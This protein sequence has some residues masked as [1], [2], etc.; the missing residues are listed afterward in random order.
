[1]YVCGKEIW[2]VETV[3]G[4]WFLWIDFTVVYKTPGTIDSEATESTFEYRF[5]IV[6]VFFQRTIV[7][8]YIFQS[9]LV[10]QVYKGII[11][12]SRLQILAVCWLVV[13]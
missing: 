1:M 8:D 7:S 11:E 4:I 12:H 9:F 10:C 3:A 2:F 5:D 13:C 6:E